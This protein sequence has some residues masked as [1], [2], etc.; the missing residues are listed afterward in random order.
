MEKKI[1]YSASVHR[2]AGLFVEYACT[3]CHG[4]EG[5]GGVPDPVQGTMVPALVGLTSSDDTGLIKSF[6][7]SDMGPNRSFYVAPSN[8]VE[9]GWINMPNWAYVLSDSQKSDL[10]AYI[11]AGLP[12]LGVKPLPARTGP[13]IFRSFACI[14]C[15][16]KPDVGGIV[17]AAYPPSS[18][19]HHVPTI[20]PK[21]YP[22]RV[23]TD[24]AAVYHDILTHGSIP[25]DLVPTGNPGTLFMPAW[26]NIMTPSQLKTILNYIQYGR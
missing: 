14:K 4:P 5:R 11:E 7:T 19:D 23:K 2:G 26:G 8:G 17:D 15:H 18:D 9:N 12:N 10:A 25:H 1:T 16:G 21:Q 20:G 6:M 3:H 24:G 13:E 22:D